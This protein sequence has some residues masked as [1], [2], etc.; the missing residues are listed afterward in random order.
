MNLFH[1]QEE[2]G[3]SIELIKSCANG[4]GIK[5]GPKIAAI[6]IRA[7]NNVLK[8]NKVFS[9]IKFLII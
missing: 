3:G 8:N 5:S 9:L 4:S 6:H 7:I 2:S 1:F